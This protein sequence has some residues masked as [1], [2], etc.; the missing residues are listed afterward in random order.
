MKEI[1]DPRN[2]INAI[3]IDGRNI[4]DKYSKEQDVHYIIGYC[5]RNIRELKSLLEW[6]E[7]AKFEKDLVE[8]TLWVNDDSS[9][10][11]KIDSINVY[12]KRGRIVQFS[13]YKRVDRETN[14]WTPIRGTCCVEWIK[15]HYY[16][17]RG[18]SLDYAMQN[19]NIVGA[20]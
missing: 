14:T 17:L 4:M 3:R 18:V 1:T 5:E 7:Q 20:L 11:I 9:E 2:V 13:G 12:E 6:A 16:D 10:F 8:A 15:D 19:C